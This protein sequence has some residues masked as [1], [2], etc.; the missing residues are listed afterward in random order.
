VFKTWGTTLNRS[1]VVGYLAILLAC[2][3]WGTA[4]MFI[5][6]INNANGGVSA[7]A[8]AFWRDLTVFAVLLIGLGLRRRAWL[9]VRKRDLIWLI[10]LG[11]SL[12]MLHVFWNLGVLLN[13]ATVMTV[14]QTAMLPIV[15][16]A[17][18]LVWG[19]PLTWRKVLSTILAF[20]GTVL[21]SGLDVWGRVELAGPKLLVGFGVP[22]TL[23]GYNLLG[24]KLRVHYHSLTILVYAFGFGAL[25]LLPFQFSVPQLW[26]VS[27]STWIWFVAL[28]SLSTIIPWC[29]Y[30]LAL[31]RLPASVASV[32]SMAEIPIVAVYAHFLLGEQLVAVQIVGTVLMV[33]GVLLLFRGERKP[34]IC[35]GL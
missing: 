2:G 28:I 30:T 9:R 32:L 29:A 10:A 21:V 34:T 4:G 27:F 25:A 6:L 17:A 22:I 23:A 3:C 7:L 35:I 26:P 16:V 11:G 14:Q 31:G 18:W 19:E 12:G 8:L 20:A 15:A 24:K 33:G 5:T 1:E 13:G